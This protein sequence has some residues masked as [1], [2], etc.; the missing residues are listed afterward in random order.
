[1]KKAFVFSIFGSYNYGNRLQNYALTSVLEKLG[2][3]AVSVHIDERI[4]AVYSKK[5]KGAVKKKLAGFGIG[6]YKQKIDIESA[7]EK[8]NVIFDRFTEEYTNSIKIP[9]FGSSVPD[10]G[11]ADYA[12]AGS[13]Q[14]WRNWTDNPK[15]L[16]HYYLTAFPKEKRIAYAASFGYDHIPF[17]DRALHKRGLSGFLENNISVRESSAADTIDSLIGRRPKEVPDPVL[18]IERFEWEGMAK[19]PS[20]HIPEKFA[21]KCMLENEDEI[22]SDIPIVDIYN[23][24]HS[25]EFITTGPSEFLWLILNCECVYT[26]S[27]HACAFS[28]I[29][30]KEFTAFKRSKNDTMF[31]RIKN[32]LKKMG[33]E[34]MEFYGDFDTKHDIDWNDV[35]LR[36]KE[37]RSI[38]FDFLN[39]ALGEKLIV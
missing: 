12:V 22:E 6:K 2:V 10:M 38:G 19:K 32:L 13:D 5:L 24:G 18:L 16:E 36:I 14:I 7:L 26:D 31:G 30:H 29:F 17:K 11:N 8:R 28:I 33:L 20:Y 3:D 34:N 27:F 9:D 25:D 23:V 37:Q 35:D 39:N 15:E 1:M 21:L 4:K